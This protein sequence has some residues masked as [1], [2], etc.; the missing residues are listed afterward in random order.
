MELRGKIEEA[1]K[2]AIRNKSEN[3]KDAL[4]MLIT[5]L[6]F[7]EKEIKRQEKEKKGKEQNKGNDFNLGM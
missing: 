7:K 6:K 4:R 2:N 1:L 5:A 3:A